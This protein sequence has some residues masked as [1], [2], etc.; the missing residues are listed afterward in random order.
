[1]STTNTTNISNNNASPIPKGFEAVTPYIIVKNS[2][3]IEFYEK[4]FGVTEEYRQSIPVNENK[5]V[6]S[7]SNIG[8]SRLM[9]DDE[10]PEMCGE[11][12]P[13]EKWV[14]LRPLEK[15]LFF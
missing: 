11:N 5:I 12:V 4:A 9:L 1:M 6:H 13:N 14:L 3:A 8:T 10:F 2:D 7:V 15:I